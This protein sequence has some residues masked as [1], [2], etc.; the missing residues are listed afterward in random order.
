MVLV[1]YNSFDPAYVDPLGRT[2]IERMEAGLAPIG[3]DGYSVEIH[4]LDQSDTGAVVEMMS[5]VH[6]SNYYEIHSNTG[7]YPSAIDRPAFNTWRNLYWK[8]R[9][10]TFS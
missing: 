3:Y 1:D 9:S 4:H 8:W 7:Q 6:K 5:S 2:N 10:T